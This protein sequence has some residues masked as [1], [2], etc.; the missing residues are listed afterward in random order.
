MNSKIP[1]LKGLTLLVTS[2]GLAACADYYGSG[3]QSYPRSRSY[4]EINTYRYNPPAVVYP[5]PRYPNSNDYN[6]SRDY[7]IKN[8]YEINHNYYSYPQDKDEDHDHHEHHHSDES[9]D[10]RRNIYYG[11]T[12]LHNEQPYPVRQHPQINTDNNAGNRI[13][14]Q[15]ENRYQ[16]NPRQDR[17]LGQQEYDKAMEQFR[18]HKMEQVRQQPERHSQDMPMQQAPERQRPEKFH[19]GTTG[20]HRRRGSQPG[21]PSE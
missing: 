1:Y 12:P 13:R 5:A 21:N 8:K 20:E 16:P 18:Q 14:E 7:S 9:D 15:R 2:L 17:T 19:N 11:N 3:Y 10:S 4:T 6:T